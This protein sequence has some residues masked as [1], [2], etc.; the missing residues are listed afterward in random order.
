MIDLDLKFFYRFHV[1]QVLSILW[2]MLI[3]IFLILALSPH[4]S[5]L[6]KHGKSL[7][8]TTN[9]PTYKLNLNV[10]KNYFTHFYIFGMFVGTA[11][12]SVNFL[13]CVG[14][15][16]ENIIQSLSLIMFLMQMFRRLWE[17]YNLT[18]F[19]ASQMT[20]FYYLGG[21]V[22]YLFVPIT[23]L[24]STLDSNKKIVLVFE[25]FTIVNKSNPYDILISSYRKND[26]PFHMF[27]IQNIRLILSIILFIF[28]SYNQYKCH[29]ILYKLKMQSIEINR[30]NYN[31]D[32]SS[33]N[34][35]NDN[36]NDYNREI[37]NH[38]NN[39]NNEFNNKSHHLL[40]YGSW[41]EL[42]ACPHYFFEILIY[43]S[44][45]LSNHIGSLSVLLLTLWVAI[46]LTVVAYAQFIWYLDNF[47]EEFN[48]DDNDNN[49][50]VTGKKKNW[51]VI[52][53][54]LF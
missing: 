17:C 28:A 42:V 24:L 22:H 50:K 43:L 54:F 5:W 40:P 37:N 48:D 21:M 31:N 52:I 36:N 33:Y 45:Y 29:F 26:K 27:T 14:S 44:F 15:L 11:C 35:Y 51:K 41:F 39:K 6:F 2:V 8:I 32:K 38:N 53:P 12:L 16:E 7:K 34:N 3:A 25:N 9:L 1:L 13:F 19:G 47:F 30:D 4:L 46:N 23:L 10:P 49:F 20:V 18:Y